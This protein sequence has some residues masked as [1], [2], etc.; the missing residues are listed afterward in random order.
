MV[1]NILIIPPLAFNQSSNA[2]VSQAI[3]SGNKKIAGT[4]LQLS[5][6][7]LTLAYIPCLVS[8]FYVGPILRMLGFSET[9][10]TLAGT[11][12]KYN[13]F[14]PIPNGWY[15]CMRF[16]F[17]AQGISRPAMYNNIVFLGVNILLNWIFVFGGPFRAWFGWNGLG[18][19]GAAISL[20]VSRSSQ[21]LIYWLYMFVYRKAHLDT[22]PGWSFGFLQRE[23]VKS[24]MDQSLPQ[25]GTLILQ[26]A[27]GQTTTLLI[28]QLGPLA[29]A[30][31]SAATAFT[32]IFTGGLSATLNAVS[33]IRVGF[34]LGA[35]QGDRARRASWIIF[36]MS[37]ASV[38]LLAVLI[39]PFGRSAMSVMTS[40]TDVQNLGA[41]LLPAVLL[42][43][44]AGLIVECN[45]GGIF[46]S[47]GRTKLA[48]FLSMGVEL[49]LSIGC[50][51]VLV[52]VLHQ[53]LVV[54]YWVQALV[55]CFEMF[56]VM[57]IFFRSDWKQYA[58]D[59]QRRQE[60]DTA[61]IFSASPHAADIAATLGT[62]A[63][64]FRSPA[65]FGSPGAQKHLMEFDAPSATIGDAE[66]DMHGADDV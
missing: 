33:G 57:I 36:K 50:V 35:G 55:M 2:L 37:S 3:G 43:T 62:P 11:F 45:T 27:I 6:F 63:R 28:A 44:F 40:D 47:Q 66:V 30:A 8:F 7:S 39:L 32:Q 16:Y 46:T 1:T 52:L 22:W 14:W 42:D 21:P 51:A 10:C 48:T 38:G 9:L 13:V 23:R 34:H 60:A 54:V 61:T 59:A 65:S 20:S 18:F 31:S 29:I 26:A 58:R 56:I 24:F 4:W 5:V 15:Q 41:L 19:I 12:A 25:V 17:Q 53:N 64:A 49:P